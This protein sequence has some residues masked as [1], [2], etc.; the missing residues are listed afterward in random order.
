MSLTT[1][2]CGREG[3]SWVHRWV[4][5]RLGGEVEWV[6]FSLACSFLT[7]RV[8]RREGKERPVCFLRKKGQERPAFGS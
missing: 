6:L 5:E 8:V 1:G 4:K 3:Q 7:I 2:F